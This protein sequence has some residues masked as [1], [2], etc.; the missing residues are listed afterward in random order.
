MR[1][2]TP[3]SVP[4]AVVS[5]L[6][7]CDGERVLAGARDVHRRWH[8]GTDAA[9]YFA[10]DE[11]YERNA[12]EDLEQATWDAD[13]SQL[14]VTGIA[15]VGEPQPQWALEFDEPGRFLEL[16]RERI[17]ASVLLTVT[18]PL[19]SRRKQSVSVIVRRSPTRSGELGFSFRLDDGLD[20][21]DPQVREAAREGL[22]QA[23]DQLGL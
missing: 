1:W 12:W 9:A 8:V 3:G 17:T 4:R 18:V 21:E 5:S 22:A 7:C 13:D 19:E 14:V 20:P 15:D 23:R 2:M 10:N 6:P 11:G 16:V